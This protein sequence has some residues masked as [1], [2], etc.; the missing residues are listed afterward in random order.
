MTPPLPARRSSGS[1]VRTACQVRPALRSAFW[2]V[3]VVL[4]AACSSTKSSTASEL[5]GSATP[6][7]LE[8][9]PALARDIEIKALE[10]SQINNEDD[11][12]RLS[13]WFQTVGE[14]AYPKLLEMVKSSDNNQK[15]FAL[16][17]IA[18]ERDVRMLE[19]LRQAAPLSTISHQAHRFEMARALLMLG[20][21][22]GVPILIEG[23]ESPNVYA[24]MKCY[25]ALKRGTNVQIPYS[26]TAS[27]QERAEGVTAWRQWW[28]EMQQ[29]DLLD[30][31]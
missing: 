7:W 27:D 6:Q 9:S 24:R 5:V 12:V 11:F 19:P 1:I 23:L 3:A 31:D 15:A 14:T 18:A 28:N 8:P 17:V 4:V 22:E 21:T 16:S 20:D 26:A 10:V 13:D 30:R 25:A 2:A 29:D